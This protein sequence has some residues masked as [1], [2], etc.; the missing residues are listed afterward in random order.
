[1]RRRVA[2]LLALVLLLAGCSRPQDVATTLRG[3]VVRAERVSRRFTYTEK[4][5][6]TV[7]AVSGVIRD[8][9]RYRASVTVNGGA[10]YEAVVSDDARAVRVTDPTWLKRLRV[11]GPGTP[12]AAP[13]TASADPVLA[14]LTAGSWVVDPHGASTFR[15][16]AATNRHAGDDPLLDGLTSL[17]YLTQAVGE[18]GKAQKFNPEATD[19]RPE[20][21][22]FPRAAPGEVRYDLLPAPLPSRLGPGLRGRAA[23]PGAINFRKIAVYLRGDMISEYREAIDVKDVLNDP[24]QDL[25]GYLKDLGIS[26]PGGSLDDQADAIVRGLNRV[27]TATG[28]E[29]IRVRSLTVRFTYGVGD[30]VEV[31]AGAVAGSLAP[32]PNPGQVLQQRQS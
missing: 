30:A 2:A 12:A 23:P 20:Q 6:A 22:P 10:A 31:P 26:P 13:G 16:T 28:A 5:G 17:Q 3:A 32:V 21:D 8:D 27:R 11:G 18:S 1:V 7:T 29:P 4:L 14:A 25:L 19:Y 15:N 24:Q 9:Y